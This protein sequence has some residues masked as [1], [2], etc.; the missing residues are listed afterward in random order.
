MVD[1]KVYGKTSFRW[2]ASQR[3]RV[4]GA[5]RVVIPVEVR[6]ALGIEKGQELTLSLT[7]DGL[8]LRTLERARARVKALARAHRKDARSVVDAF[9]AA[10]RAEAAGEP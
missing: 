3:V 1:H 7:D 5:G 8:T 6:K 4:D 2:E 10:R 9:L